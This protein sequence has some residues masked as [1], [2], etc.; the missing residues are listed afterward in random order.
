MSKPLLSLAQENVVFPPPYKGGEDILGVPFCND[1]TIAI[2]AMSG[3]A[4]INPHCRSDHPAS[5]IPPI[6]GGKPLQFVL[7]RAKSF[8]KYDGIRKS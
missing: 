2:V 7:S 6:V 4:R 5:L 3:S 1:H 8:E